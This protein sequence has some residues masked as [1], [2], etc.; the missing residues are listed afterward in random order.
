[1]LWSENARSVWKC[2]TES[3]SLKP[4]PI[5]IGVGKHII[6]EKLHNSWIEICLCAENAWKVSR[7]ANALLSSGHY[8]RIDAKNLSVELVRAEVACGR[9]TIPT[10]K[11][12]TNLEPMG[13]GIAFRC[14]V[15]A[16]IGVSPNASDINNN[17]S[18]SFK[19]LYHRSCIELVFWSLFKLPLAFEPTAN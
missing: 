15:N 10:N 8:H 3:R 6:W 18:D 11:N 16:N 2:Q 12:H 9:A 17:T 1:M 5:D 19:T 13:I 14:K 7:Y 4:E